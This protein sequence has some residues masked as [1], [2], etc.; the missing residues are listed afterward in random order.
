MYKTPLLDPEYIFESVG[1]AHL[2]CCNRLD[3][4]TFKGVNI[5]KFLGIFL[6]VCVGV[7]MNELMS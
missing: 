2:Q 5:Y 7:G 6:L 3:H 1:K 4:I